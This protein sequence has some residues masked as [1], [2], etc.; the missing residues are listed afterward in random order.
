MII[1]SWVTRNTPA[2]SMAFTSTLEI[3]APS[4]K[5][6]PSV[7]TRCPDISPT[8][9]DLPAP[10]SPSKPWMVPRRIDSD[11]SLSAIVAP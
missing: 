4:R 3:G 8:S 6:A 7:G 2:F 10:F 1:G 9:V 5:I 11:T